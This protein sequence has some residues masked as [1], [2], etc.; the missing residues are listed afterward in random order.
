MASIFFFTECLASAVDWQFNPLRTGRVLDEGGWLQEYNLGS[1]N[2][3]PE[4]NF[5]LQLV[6]LNTRAN[7]GLFG[8]Q[9]YCPQLESSVVP[10]GAGVFIWQMP[11]GT[12]DVFRV[13]P[14][15]S[16]GYFDTSRQWF[17]KYDSDRQ[18]IQNQEGWLYEYRRG[19]LV[20]VTSPTN[21]VLQFNWVNDQLQGIQLQ[22][23]GAGSGMPLLQAA[24]TDSK[25]I[26]NL[27]FGSTQHQ[28]DYLSGRDGRLGDWWAPNKQ[29]FSFTY[30]DVGV[31]EYIND[32]TIGIQTFTTELDDPKLESS[33]QKD[34]AHWRLVQ[35]P[36]QKYAYPDKTVRGDATFTTTSGTGLVV[37]KDANFQRG[38]VT[39]TIA[40]GAV[41]K[42]YYYR[43]PG[44]KYDGK[45]RRIE[46][47]GK[48][49][50]E[51][52]YSRKSGLL[53]S[54]LD[55]H[56][57]MI[58]FDYPDNWQP[59]RDNPWDP[60]P[61]RVWKGT[62][63]NPQ[64]LAAY[65]YDAGG[66]VIAAQNQAGQITRYAYD[67]RNQLASVT[68]PQGVTTTVSYDS[69]GRP[70]KAQTGSVSHAVTYDD[71]GRVKSQTSTDG[72]E[73]DFG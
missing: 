47:N 69:L 59:T 45:L 24:Y 18:L 14:N 65:Q 41:R 46:E 19:H 66:H 27:V 33:A 55:E 72:V 42:T 30:A 73:T 2:A 23:S 39:E 43:A 13:D 9:W 34:P 32:S 4:F 62:P 17:A 35:D 54:M 3:S 57:T 16:T 56:G 25:R 6:Y 67:D 29:R 5:P 64:V 8:P 61:I 22:D 48:V 10:E 36:D 52:Y 20:A 44:Q 53:T 31:L 63:D 58:Y 70:V 37:D 11:S 68:N 40:G 50:V 51:Y 21:R 49:M 71:M 60:K 7:A 26:N 28:F 1:I 15:N 12:I 38:I